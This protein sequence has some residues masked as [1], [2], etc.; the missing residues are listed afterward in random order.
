MR[1]PGGLLRA[2]GTLPGDV[3]FTAVKKT[4]LFE[5][6]ARQI[7]AL[8]VD[9]AL[10]T[11]DL[12]PP[13]RELAERF[14]VSRSSVR[15]AIRTLEFVG[16]VV[17]RQ[18]EGTVVADV[19]PEAVVMPIASVL[20]RKREL[21]EEL[22]DIR[23]MIE[24]ALAARAAE[25]ATPEEIA[26]LEDVLKRQRAKTQRGE[27]A[28]EEDAEFHYQL[29]LAAKNGVVRRVIDVLMRLLRETRARSLQT[30]GRPE[31]SL[32]GHKRILDAIKRRDPAAAERA[33]RRHVEEIESIV[34]K[35]L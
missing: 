19:S 7:Q 23:K 30:H 9:G 27:L 22:L 28:V 4:R 14:G 18:G 25:R 21:I 2:G 17:P 3:A 13:E 1:S 32:A 29:A 6:V 11:G 20:G 24:P 33:V 16:L 34:L 12:L 8:I 26:R 5:G 31:R 10:K 35:K 15:D